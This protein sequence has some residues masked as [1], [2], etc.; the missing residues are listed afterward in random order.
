MILDASPQ[1]SSTLRIFKEFVRLYANAFA[2]QSVLSR[3]VHENCPSGVAL[4]R[5]APEKRTPLLFP[6][7]IMSSA[8]G[9]YVLEAIN[10]ARKGDVWS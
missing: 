2:F 5:T 1:L 8:E 10:A 9:A 6:G 3:A 4:S 7:G